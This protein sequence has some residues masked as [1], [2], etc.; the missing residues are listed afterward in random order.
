M[1]RGIYYG[2][3]SAALFGV[4]TPLSKAL[5]GAIA[6]LWLASILYIGAGVGLLVVL[7]VRRRYDALSP[8]ALP[9]GRDW[10]WVGSAI[11][12]G[13]IAGPVALMYGLTSTS[14]ATATLLLNL[15]A[16]LTALVA[17]FVFHENFDRRI[18]LGMAVIVLG[19]AILAASPAGAHSSPMGST[20]VTV[21]CLCW[22]LDNNLTRRASASDPVLLASLKGLVAGT[23]NAGLAWVLGTPMPTLLSAGA[24][25]VVGFAGY[26]VSLVLFILALRHLGT[27]RT[28]AYFS[29]GPFFGAI[30]ALFMGQ[31]ALTWSFVVAAGL[32]ALGVWLHVSERHAHEHLHEPQEHI[33]SH[34]HDEHHRHEHAFA[35]DGSEPHTHRHFHAALRHSHPHYP[36]LHHRHRHRPGNTAIDRTSAAA[37]QRK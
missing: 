17:W 31:G 37:D 35:W 1:K 10:M 16:V 22:A 32:M 4:S 12:L 19:A 21:A 11:A 34:V 30:V 2:L 33:H 29:V 15:E 25:A 8:L 23:A 3:A 6:P 14:G 13:G 36:D 5:V 24:G 27:A 9:T 28:S 7:V 20:L 26:G 18:A